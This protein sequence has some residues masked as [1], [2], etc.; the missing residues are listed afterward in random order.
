MDA[1]EKLFIKMEIE[2]KLAEKEESGK[3]LIDE[4]EDE[5]KPPVTTDEKITPDDNTMN[6][7]NALKETNASQWLPFWQT[8][9]NQLAEE[10][11]T[12]TELN[13]KQKKKIHL[14]TK[15]KAKLKNLKKSKLVKK[16][17]DIVKPDKKL[18]DQSFKVIKFSKHVGTDNIISE[19]K[20]KEGQLRN[21]VLVADNTLDNNYF[22][23]DI[24]II[25]KK[26][27]IDYIIA[28]GFAEE[29]YMKAADI[30]LKLI[31]CR[32]SNLIEEG[33][34]IE[35]FMKEKMLFD[36]NNGQE[37][38]FMLTTDPVRRSIVQKMK[39][40]ES[41]TIGDNLHI[42]IVDICKD[43]VKLCVNSLKVVTIYIHKN[44]TLDDVIKLKV[45]KAKLDQVSLAIDT[46]DN[47][48]IIR[49]I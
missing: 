14:L 42:K 49:D 8:V 28:S 20:A 18:N 44:T 11:E 15:Y 3:E 37:Y 5:K 24:L 40:G 4:K 9:F 16:E 45:L 10:E 43:Q 26:A 1:Y 22:N 13:K 48:T 19:I 25:I 38:K 6:K 33:S 12:N 30:G 17:P 23:D 31:N 34:N 36:V 27:G 46:P 35:V 29:L 39:L 21:H 47:I 2:K 7:K 41:L 32:D